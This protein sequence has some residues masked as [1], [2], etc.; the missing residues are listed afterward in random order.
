MPDGRRPAG[1]ESF[2][3]QNARTRRFTLGAPRGFQVSPDGSRVVFLRSKAGDDPVTCLW[4]LDVGSGE[5]RLICDPGELAA[6]GEE[7]AEE[8]ARRE[9][10]REQA[11][12]IV[13]Y[14]T[15]A[16]ARL[17]AFAL[18]GRLFVANLDGPGGVREVP[19]AGPV[20]DPRPDPAGDRVAYVTGRALHAVDLTDGRDRLLAGEDDPE[21]SWG[22]A[23]FVAAE[24]MNR[25]RGFWWSPDGRTLAAA[26]VDTSPVQRWHISNPAEPSAPPV[27]VAYPSAG[28]ANAAVTLHLL[29]PDGTRVEVDWDHLAFPYLVRAVWAEGS[30]PTLLVFSRDQRHSAVLEADPS[31]GEAR[32]VREET[33][34]AWVEV[35]RG[36]P[37]RLDDGRLVTTTDLDDTRRLVVGDELVTPPGLQVRAVLGV[38]PDVL[39]AATEEATETHVWRWSTGAGAEKLTSEP[40]VHAAVS[41][42]STLVVTSASLDRDGTRTLV[43]REGA[44]ALEIHSFAERPVLRADVTL[45]RLGQRRLRSALLLPRD[46]VLREPGVK[47]PV[48]LDPYGGPHFQRV[49]AARGAFAT[50]QWFADQGF[51]VLVT[52]G[53]GSPGRGTAWEKAVHL[54]LAGPVLQDQIDAL[55]A[56]AED[57]ARLDMSRVAIRGWSFGGFLAALAVLRRPDVF[58]AAVAGAPVTDQR[59]YDTFYTERYLGDPN[60]DPEPYERSS[61]LRDAP[62]LSR[63]LMIIHGLVDDNVVVANSL[64]LSRALLEAGRPHVFLPLSGVTHMTPQEEVAENLLRLELGFLRRALGITGAN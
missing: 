49:V 17:A 64:R 3:R 10:V 12:G 35:V 47:L 4:V 9:R 13:A 5:E 15:D 42:A 62:R 61:L 43:R 39:F 30:P 57:D 24:E 33:D 59:L 45:L 19:A 52:D 21:V 27:A 51:A 40:G 7:P 23:E 18:G 54:D 53:R 50:S 28:T 48:L 2:P 46:P 6:A 36:S 16:A 26:R 63:P 31:T 34:P 60:E 25:T 44:E 38:G 56:A 37:D 8:R 1:A 22:L 32:A 20:V 29:G 55:H 14:A 41:G 11:S 58:H